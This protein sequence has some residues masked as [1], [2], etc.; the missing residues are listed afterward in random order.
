MNQQRACGRFVVMAL[1]AV[2]FGLPVGAGAGALL[3][4]MP[5]SPARACDL[6]Q[7]GVHSR[8]VW[9]EPN[10]VIPTNARL[11]VT[12]HGSSRVA[13]G[14]IPPIGTD[15]VLL[16]PDGQP[17]AASFEVLGE[18]VVVRPSTAMLPASGYQLAD[19]RAIPCWPT[20]ASACA[21]VSTHQVFASFRT[22]AQPDHTAPQFEG[23]ADLSVEMLHTC[24][25]SACCGPYSRYPIHLAWSA[26]AD[27]IVPDAV[28]YNLYAATGRLAVGFIRGTT[29]DAS[30]Y[31][32]GTILFDPPLAPGTY[33]LRA[34]DWAGNE[35]ANTVEKV[36][37]NA[38]AGGSGGSGGV[39]VGG[40]SGT[41]GMPSS[42][43]GGVPSGAGTGGGGGAGDPGGG[44]PVADAGAGGPRA[45][46]RDTGCGCDVGAGS[47]SLFSVLVGWALLARARARHEWRRRQVPG[48]SATESCRQQ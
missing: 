4:V 31:C 48:V 6:A 41:G 33:V 25:N 46:S 29:L 30:L 2:L 20:P 21:L 18:H 28:R 43:T 27:E 11:V 38:C 39:G 36:L 19:R 22:G 32:A 24:T 14:Q 1:R 9:P 3:L 8:E 12:Y 7:P 17:V 13:A 15:L 23:L 47:V 44:L 35:D 5:A 45:A 34:V 10:R 37:P 16:G 42:G 26:G 40:E